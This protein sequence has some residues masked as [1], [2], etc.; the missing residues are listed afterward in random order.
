MA[1]VCRKL[2]DRERETGPLHLKMKK[3]ISVCVYNCVDC[4]RVC[5][6]L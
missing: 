1:E 2:N 3:M 4:V 5:R 6:H